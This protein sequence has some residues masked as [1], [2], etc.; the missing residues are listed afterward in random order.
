[1]TE[2]KKLIIPFLVDFVLPD[3]W[4][5]GKR[6]RFPHKKDFFERMSSS[7]GSKINPNIYIWWIRFLYTIEYNSTNSWKRF[8]R[9]GAD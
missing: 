9:Y 6:S 4:H 5:A 8:Y 1:M 2:K 7:C 3:N